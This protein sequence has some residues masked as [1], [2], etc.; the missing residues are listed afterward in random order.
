MT[1]RQYS[2]NSLIQELE[3]IHDTKLSEQGELAKA[4]AL[5][6]KILS[7]MQSLVHSKETF[8]S[9]G[10]LLV[11]QIVAIQLSIPEP[12]IDTEQAEQALARINYIR[13]NKIYLEWFL[14][15]QLNNPNYSFKIDISITN[16]NSYV[17]KK[18]KTI[19]NI[20]L[21]RH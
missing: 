13:N 17:Y 15:K 12:G 6:D 20:L 3:T 11:Y 1:Y 14:N 21:K 18:T 5:Y 19:L 2:M 10:S 9:D 16:E 8:N 7:K 4:Q